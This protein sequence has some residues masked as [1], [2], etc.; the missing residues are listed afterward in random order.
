MY[1][2]DGDDNVTVAGNATLTGLAYGY[3]NVTVYAIDKLGNIGTSETVFFTLSEPFPT[4]LVVAF[5]LIVAVVCIGL[6]V[7]FKKRKH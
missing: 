4:T 3:H 6:T 7:Y 2:L 1:S 5:V